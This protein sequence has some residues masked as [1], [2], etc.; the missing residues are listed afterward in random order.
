MH[1]EFIINVSTYIAHLSHECF[2][3]VTNVVVFE[4]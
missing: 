3:L 1:N 4:P 2:L